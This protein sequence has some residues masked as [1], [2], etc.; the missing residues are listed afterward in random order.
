MTPNEAINTAKTQLRSYFADENIRDLGLEEVDFSDDEQEWR[1]TLGF[2]RP[3]DS[4]RGIVAD[5]VRP[6]KP[7]RVYKVVHVPENDG[8]G[9]VRIKNREVDA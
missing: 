9:K 6:S 5:M 1:I 3:W 4:E 7:N 8:D 2:S